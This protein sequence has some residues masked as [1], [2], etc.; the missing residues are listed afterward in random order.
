MA[1]KV[2]FSVNAQIRTYLR[3][4]LLSFSLHQYILGLTRISFSAAVGEPALCNGGSS[5]LDDDDRLVCGPLPVSCCL[6]II[7]IITLIQ[8][9]FYNKYLI[10]N[11]TKEK[12]SI[13]QKHDA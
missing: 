4:Y 5:S 6:K 1:K 7:N 12:I 13:Y 3:L 11:D 8:F 10:Y 9:N 2:F